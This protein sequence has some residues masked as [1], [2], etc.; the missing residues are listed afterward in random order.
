M[1]ERTESVPLDGDG[2]FVAVWLV[3]T[4]GV[5][6]GFAAFAVDLGNWYLGQSRAQ[7]AADAAAMGGMVFLPEDRGSAQATVHT[8]AAQH[9]IAPGQVR[10]TYAETGELEVCVDETV[11]N[12]FLPVI[13]LPDSKTLSACAKAAFE[14]ALEMG[15]PENILGND[16]ESGGPQPGFVLGVAGPDWI[17]ADGD[18]HG[19]GRCG[20]AAA[21]A[22]V[23][24][25]NGFPIANEEYSEDGY[26]FGVTVTAATGQPLRV[27]IYDPAW[28]GDG[29][30]LD[31]TRGMPSTTQLNNLY[32]LT[33]HGPYLVGGQEV[34]PQGWFDDVHE[35][36]QTGKSEWCPGDVQHGNHWQREPMQTTFIM[37][38]PDDTPWTDLDNPV[39]DIPTCQPTSF[40]TYDIFK[41]SH[42]AGA[43]SVYARLHPGISPS[44]PSDYRVDPDDGE[45]TFSEVFRRWVNWCEIPA[46]QV[47]PGTYVVQVR[48][49]A[50]PSNP[51]AYDPTFQTYGVNFF[52][53][54]AGFA[55]GDGVTSAG[56]NVTLA[57]LGKL[58]IFA[59]VPGVPTDFYLGRVV[60]VD[61]Q[62]TLT[63]EAFDLGDAASAGTL[64]VLPPPDAN[65]HLFGDCEFA[66]NDGATLNFNA[67]QCLLFNVH[68]NFGYDARV[69]I[70][71]VPI[72]EDYTCA[73][74][75]PTG[76][77]V[78]LRM[79]FPSDV[80]DFTTWTTYVG[81][82]VRLVE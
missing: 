42:D 28:A 16:P 20:T 12:V 60:P 29:L 21:G 41:D 35:R 24:F 65:Y 5:M 48:T 3:I 66:R 6:V 39:V 26:T 82:P 52:S 1:T 9:G 50:R 55:D 38:E 51:L 54:R 15:S 63:V 77:W 58:P 8:I 56:G 64:Q 10:I 49:N 44:H 11:G 43:T 62:R 36:Y 17:K 78:R 32:N 27:Q 79:S 31:C 81:E 37:R 23:A 33:R 30:T 70:A 14:R 76:C 73:Q 59:N 53:M 80:H 13:G 40:G 18:R 2:G 71:K 25:C 74:H 68:R 61:R 75:L 19:A 7:N 22:T 4:F 45:W 69:I 47:K 57:A 72:P 34:I 67:G 46:D